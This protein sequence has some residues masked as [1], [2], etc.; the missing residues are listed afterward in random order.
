[1]SHNA[2]K[3]EKEDFNGNFALNRWCSRI[4]TTWPSGV[5]SSP[6]VA[7]TSQLPAR[8]RS[9]VCGCSGPS[10]TRSTCSTRRPPLL[11]RL[12]L[13][14]RGE[15]EEEGVLTRPTAWPTPR[16]APSR[17][18]WRPTVSRATTRPTRPPPPPPQTTSTPRPSYPTPTGDDDT[19]IIV[20]T[21]RDRPKS[22][23][24]LRLKNVRGTTIGKIWKFFRSRKKF[25]TTYAIVLFF[26]LPTFSWKFQISQKL[27]I[28]FSRNFAQSFHTQRG[29]CVCKGIKIV[30]LGCEKHSQN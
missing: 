10:S 19:I 7:S 21:S 24:Y 16:S 22:A 4:N 1:M 12:P 2:E 20:K 27:S 6:P 9:S 13:S 5:W 14:L 15:E 17:A 18:V 8:T 25:S 30:W 26:F 11:L 3:T 29:P 23:P 28:R